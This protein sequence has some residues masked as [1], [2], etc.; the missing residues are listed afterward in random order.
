M[1]R[2]RDELAEILGAEG[3]RA[4]SAE[5]GGR[6]ALIPRRIPDGHWIE[7]AAGREAADALAFRFGGCRIYIPRGPSRDLAARDRRV[8]D[9]RRQGL[10]VSE[11]ALREGLSDR[12]IFRILKAGGGLT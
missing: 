1:P 3:L 4:L 8:L 2:L 11:I 7:R 12:W 5:R 10:S 6:R 9:L